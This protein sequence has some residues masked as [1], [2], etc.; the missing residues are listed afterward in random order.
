[1]GVWGRR[2]AGR[3]GVVGEGGRGAGGPVLFETA[4]AGSVGD[5]LTGR[6]GLRHRVEG[7]GSELAASG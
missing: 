5:P 4:A 2:V 1:M 7:F 6:D 3:R